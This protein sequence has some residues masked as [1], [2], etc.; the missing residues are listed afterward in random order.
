MNGR[1][2]VPLV[3][4]AGETSPACGRAA[5][6]ADAGRALARVE[7][8][9]ATA[10]PLQHSLEGRD[11][12][13]PALLVFG[14]GLDGAVRLAAGV[15]RKR[16]VEHLL[17]LVRPGE[18]EVLRR[19]L[20]YSALPVP[21]TVLPE[22][23]PEPGA[24]LA[25]LLR[26]IAQRTRFR[27]TLD[28]I[29]L[30]LQQ[31]VDPAAYRHLVVSS[32]YT[33]SILRH[34]TDAIFSTDASGV[35]LTWNRGSE[36][37]FGLDERQAL[38]R[39][40]MELAE[41]PQGELSAAV[42]GVL[43]G[44]AQ[45]LELHARSRAGPIAV[46]MTLTPVKDDAGG[47]IGT[48]AIV[49]D[50]AERLRHEQER[51]RMI[52]AERAAR[53][54]LEQAG[55][56]KDEF[57]AILSHE[58]KTPLSAMLGFASVLQR[59]AAADPALAG[60]VE[61]ILRNGR[62]QARLIDDLLDM[63]AISVGKLRL[64]TQP[65]SLRTRA[66]DVLESIRPAAS[67]RG[68]AL[69]LEVEDGCVVHAD[70]HRLA[71]VLSNLLTNAVKFSREGGRVRL[72]VR[73][74]GPDVEIAVSDQ[75]E[76]MDPAT[77]E[78]VFDRFWQ[79]DSSARRRHGGLGLGL[80]IA[81]QLVEL[82]GGSVHAQSA[83]RGKGATFTVRLPA[84]EPHDRP[85][86][87]QAADPPAELDGLNVLIVDDEPDAREVLSMVM[88]TLGASAQVADGVD[89]GL[90]LLAR[91]HFDL[92]LS[93]ISMPGRNGYEFVRE[94]RA[95]PRLKHLPAIAVTAFGRAEDRKEALQAG[96]D[97]HVAKPVELPAL[98]NAIHQVVSRG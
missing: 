28:R 31:P 66:T 52:E 25:N 46:D 26:S 21:W 29:N 89:Q 53:A 40:I 23:E 79:A 80:S 2:A 16:L 55:R 1:P 95:Q 22:T 59:A 3:L 18:E 70:P 48:A 96:Y 64:E 74:S 37:L 27:T 36:S 19:S 54:A 33:E 77:L 76:G 75:G 20:S 17:F 42:D 67:A 49:R 78:Q 35:V 94:L 13:A 10:G 6:W 4:V 65:S 47:V 93:D 92:L 91:E 81:R 62:A 8:C 68:V 72:H 73:R 84:A 58:L 15:A 14:P 51:E 90:A 60:P 98:L 9:P 87:A 43:A 69:D 24:V 56:M 7:C 50:I 44:T 5:A 39:P 11:P 45:R 88:S 61:A 57:L 97:A 86:P 12:T 63:S 41:W 85:S 82:H 83:G 71:Q 38:G 30:Q 34:A 32:R